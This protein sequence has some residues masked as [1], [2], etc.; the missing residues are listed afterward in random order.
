[1]TLLHHF[2]DVLHGASVVL[3]VVVGDV[4]DDCEVVQ[5]DLDIQVGV[6]G[7]NPLWIVRVHID[8]VHISAKHYGISQSSFS[9][10]SKVVL[11]L[12]ISQ[13]ACLL[14]PSSLALIVVISRHFSLLVKLAHNLVQFLLVLYNFEDFVDD[15]LIPVQPFFL[16]RLT[17][18][19]HWF[20]NDGVGRWR[21]RIVEPAHSSMLPAGLGV[22][23]SVDILGN[24]DHIFANSLFMGGNSGEEVDK[25]GQD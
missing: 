1:M 22:V 16:G 5:N 6:P 12:D 24:L 10:G 19:F 25:L 2:S 18:C 11:I 9:Q 13:L 23:V 15:Q 4:G 7:P 20:G 21:F 17:I 3:G 8:L 14:D